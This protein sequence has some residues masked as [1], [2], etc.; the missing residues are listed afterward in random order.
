M[1]PRAPQRGPIDER[2]IASHEFGKRILP[3]AAGEGMKKFGVRVIV[4]HF[5][6]RCPMEIRQKTFSTTEFSGIALR[7]RL[8]LPCRISGS[9]PIH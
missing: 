2:T 6:I 4:H 1:I 3:A 5:I 9:H 8:N 7:H